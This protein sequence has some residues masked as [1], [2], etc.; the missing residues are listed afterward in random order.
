MFAMC[1]FIAMVV[2]VFYYNFLS[3]GNSIFK[4]SISWCYISL[5]NGV[6]SPIKKL[7]VF[8]VL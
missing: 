4:L 3:L 6:A 2:Y 7:G 5:L 8:L 1:L